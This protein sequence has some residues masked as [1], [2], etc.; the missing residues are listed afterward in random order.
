MTKNIRFGIIGCS[1]IAESSTIPAIINSNNAEL[2][3]IGSRSIKK[4]EKFATKFNCKNFGTYEDVMTSENVDAVYISVPVGLHAKYSIESA[5]H[6]K[7]ILCEKSSASSLDESLNMLTSCKEN[8]VRIME[9]FMFRFHPQ[10]SKVQ[11]LISQKNIGKLFHFSGYYGF[12]SMSDDDIRFKHDLGGGILNDAGCY[13]IC[14]S[15]ITFNEEPSGV[16]CK[17]QMNEKNHVDMKSS[18]FL[19]Y[20][21]GK[22]A[23]M[24]T[25]YN[26]N[27]Q[28]KYSIW[29]STGHLQLQRA[30][31]VP[32]T[33]NT[34]ILFS[35]SEKEEVIK[36]PHYNHFQL[37][38]EHF[39]LE[40]HGK[41][42][43]S[44]NPENDL[45]KQA[46]VMEAARI[47]NTENR[48]VKID[49]LI[50]KF[51]L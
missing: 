6:G 41:K 37:M 30:Y 9:G 3:F 28:S 39:S 5:K 42:N 50:S 22:T 8:Q 17:L 12:P 45:L 26:L 31:N 21:D 24:A 18:I 33:E 51:E 34:M 11:E 47:S 7:H 14:A 49:E 38:I 19:D 1:R 13:P 2:S 48:Y 4:A 36:I 10:H 44:F 25:G 29:G 16:L 32:P 43:L 40:L 20:S 15:R 35:N 23:C 27:F 46:T